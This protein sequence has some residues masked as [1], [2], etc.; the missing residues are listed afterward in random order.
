M[1]LTSHSLRVAPRTALLLGALASALCGCATTPPPSPGT[2]RYTD[3]AESRYAAAMQL[4]ESESWPEAT[5]AFRAVRQDYSVSRF[6][7]LAELRLA[8]IDFKQE[9]YAEALSAY[10]AW[11][12]YHAS[13]SEAPYARF[14]IARCHLEQ[15]PEDWFLTP[16]SWERDLSAAHDAETALARFVRDHGTSEHGPEA[17]RHLRHV[18][19]VLARHEVYVANFY[20]SRDHYAAAASRLLGVLSNFHDSGLEALALLRLGEVYL[21][22]NH[23]ADARGAFTQIVDAFPSA[24]EAAAA[25]EHL[26]RLGPG[27]A[28][29]VR[30]EGAPATDADD[31]GAIEDVG[32]AGTTRETP[33]PR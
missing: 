17:R 18:R 13:Q 8:D 25:R 1:P 15:L 5:E 10:R 2:T 3:E 12:R 14:M 23:A 28:T 33:P 11:L 29:P 30:P 6:A 22:M 26:R 9:H 27:E 31:T 4:Y 16:P 32:T 21:R 24:A 20:S 7:V 19:E